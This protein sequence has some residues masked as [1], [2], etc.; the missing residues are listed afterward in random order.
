MIGKDNR[1]EAKW[2]QLCYK[3]KYLRQSFSMKNYLFS[4]FRNQKSNKITYQLKNNP[5]HNNQAILT[6]FRG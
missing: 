6:S 2:F 3:I 4:N 1:F 5:T